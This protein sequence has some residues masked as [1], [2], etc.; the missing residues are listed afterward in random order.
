[1]FQWQIFVVSM[2]ILHHTE[3]L[4]VCLWFDQRAYTRDQLPQF[5]SPF[6]TSWKRDRCTFSNT[7]C[8]HTTCEE[9][10]GFTQCPVEAPHLAVCRTPAAVVQEQNILQPKITHFRL[11]FPTV[12][13]SS[14]PNSIKRVHVSYFCNKYYQS[15][16]SRHEEPIFGSY[17]ASTDP[18]TRVGGG[19]IGLQF[20]VGGG[21]H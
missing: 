19:L 11:E 4:P 10:E 17:E 16:D 14:T 12:F 13:S 18:K 6:R 8:S 20:W 15:V 7:G 9:S 3:T 21:L 1:M 5:E 2:R